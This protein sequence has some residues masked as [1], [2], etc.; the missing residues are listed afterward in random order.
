MVRRAVAAE[1]RRAAHLVLDVD[2]AQGALDAIVERSSTP[3]VA[4]LDMGVPDM[5]GVELARALREHP[6]MVDL[7]VLFLSARV[8]AE[9]VETIAALG[10]SVLTKPVTG[11]ALLAA[12]ERCT[13]TPA[14]P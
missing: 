3:D 5:D 2:S 8:S 6:R 4:V 14:S 7:P 12:I 9:D 1:L 10:C 11:A 13:A